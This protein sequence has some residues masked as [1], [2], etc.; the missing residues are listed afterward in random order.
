MN[1]INI[2]SVAF[3]ACAALTAGCSENAWNDHLDGFEEP[4]VYSKTETVEYTLTSDDYQ[5]IAKNSTNRTLAEEAG[6]SD[7]LAAIGSNGYFSTADEARKYLP[8]FISNSS[9]KY[10]AL[11]NGS[12]VKVTYNLVTNQPAEVLAI[13]SSVSQ[14][15][16]SEE[17]YQEAWGSTEDYIGAFAPAAPA[18]ASLPAILKAAYPNATDGQ[19]AVAEYN[20]ATTNPVFGGG[21]SAPQTY[22]EL[23]FKDG[24]GDFTIENRTLPEGLS[25]IWSQDAKYGMKASAY[26]GGVNYDAESWLISPEMT[27]SKEANAVLNFTQ[28]LNFFSSVS[29]AM[30]EATVNVREKGGQ[31]TKLTVPN[32]PEKLSWS[33]LDSGDI[34]LSAYNGKTIQIGFC[35]KS[36]AA[37]SGTWEIDA[38]K[39]A[40][41]GK[42]T[43]SLTR[44]AAAEVPSEK[45]FAIYRYSEGS[46]TVP[47]STYVLQPSDYEAMGQSY[48]NLSGDLPEQLLPLYMAQK[49]P[50][51]SDDVA[52]IVAY[53]Y[54][55][56]DKKTSYKAK[57]LTKTADGWVLNTGATVDQFT[58]MDGVWKFNPSV[59]MTL[60]YS[61][62]TD[63][64]YSYFMAVKDWVYT[65]I[66][67]KLYP[68]AEP[69]AANKIGYPFIDYR[70]NAEF[71]SGASAYYGNVDIRSSTAKNNAPAG[72]TGYDGLSDEQI[73][74]LIKKRFA[75]ES[76]PGALSIMHPDAE[77][78][79]GMDVTY[80]YTFT[81]Y[82]S[83]GSLEATAVYKVVAKGQF[84]FVSCTWWDGGKPAE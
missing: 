15:R 41:G 61:R 62:N 35:Y 65:N 18:S 37:K 12:S 10:F 39:L 48:G 20:E 31:W 51:A 57:E 17:N 32:V 47:G 66:S 46:W 14:Y 25:F 9:F 81:A 64:T 43:R 28:A 55:D 71:Y 36:T 72:Y 34:D 84:E 7:A 82:T 19:Y 53:K 77:P 70:D 21:S 76:F 73:T 45:K 2:K 1:R 11:N 69:D 4:P 60:P 58:R 42:D 22:L 38:V 56:A 59:V 67:R 16:V 13:N 50:Y 83:T 24:Q 26:A 63:P 40:D 6:E 29:V 5:T 8:A 78:V 54:Y 75:T 79:A 52:A 68:D 80:T 23:S 44:A 49:L 74:E 27:L 3:L 30:E 33:F